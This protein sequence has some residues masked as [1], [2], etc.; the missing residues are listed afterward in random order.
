VKNET[1]AEV[2]KSGKNPK[3]ID[4]EQDILAAVDYLFEK[5]Q[6][7]IIIFGSSYSAS[8]ALKIAN[9]NDHVFAA[10]AFSPGE[11]FDQKN[12][13]AS[14]IKGMKKPVFI[15]S[16]KAEADAV[17][18]LVKDVE[19]RLKVQYVPKD[20][21]DHGSKVLWSDKP[22]N[23]DYWAALMSFLNRVKEEK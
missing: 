13:I 11:Y 18:D 6:K 23:Q 14:H 2:K 9:E 20:E 12:F 3:Y 15:S 4:C 8:L 21:G 1:A 7:K 5:Y 19:S 17:T 22:G 16:S 10:V